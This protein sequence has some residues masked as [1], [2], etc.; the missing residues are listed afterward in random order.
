MLSFH[1]YEA[2][3][4]LLRDYE[5]NNPFLKS[6]VTLLLTYHFYLFICLSVLFFFSRKRV[7]VRAYTAEYE[8]KWLTRDQTVKSQ[9][10]GLEN[11][12]V[13][14]WENFKALETESV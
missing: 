13:G 1:N 14:K 11:A 4:R 6:G 2:T 7:F 9:K 12:K 5:N 3:Y 8:C 10:V